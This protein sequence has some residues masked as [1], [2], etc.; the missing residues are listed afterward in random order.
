MQSAKLNSEMQYQKRNKVGA[1]IA[2]L[3]AEI[4][5]DQERLKHLKKVL[6]CHSPPPRGIWTAPYL[7]TA[8]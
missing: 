7:I 4:S 8:Y 3:E 5:A 1:A 6:N 2:K